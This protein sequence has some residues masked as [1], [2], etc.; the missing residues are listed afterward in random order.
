[1]LKTF[2]VHHVFRKSVGE[3]CHPHRDPIREIVGHLV[4][5]RIVLVFT[6]VPYE[7][8]TSFDKFL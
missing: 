6:K 4:G 3:N 2:A 5:T 7:F 1:M 8:S